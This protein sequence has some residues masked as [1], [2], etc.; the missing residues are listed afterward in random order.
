MTQDRVQ[1]DPRE[2]AGYRIPPRDPAHAEPDWFETG[3]DEELNDPDAPF[4]DPLPT[5]RHRSIPE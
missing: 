5:A 1:A 2:G 4:I 3:K